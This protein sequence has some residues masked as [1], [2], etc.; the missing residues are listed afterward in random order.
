MKLLPAM[1]ALTLLAACATTAPQRAAPQA[2]AATER[3]PVSVVLFVSDGASF[4]TWNM[5][6]YLR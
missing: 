6:G 3:Q 2:A 5:A 1:L 4:K